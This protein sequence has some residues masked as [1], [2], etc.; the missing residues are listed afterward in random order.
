[1]EYMVRRGF[2]SK[3]KEYFAVQADGDTMSGVVAG[4]FESR[5]Q[6]EQAIE[7]LLP[8]YNRRLVC[9]GGHLVGWRTTVELGEP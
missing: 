5:I 6:C 7:A 4:P 3:V 8:L 2:H 9:I 1:M